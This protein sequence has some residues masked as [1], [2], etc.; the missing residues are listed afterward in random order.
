MPTARVYFHLFCLAQQVFR[1][2][3][4]PN[5]FPDFII[6]LMA[7]RAP[8]VPSWRH[9]RNN[10]PFSLNQCWTCRR[11]IKSL[12]QCWPVLQRRQHSGHEPSARPEAPSEAHQPPI[13]SHCISKSGRSTKLIHSTCFFPATV[14]V[15]CE[16]YIFARNKLPPNSFVFHQRFFRFALQNS[17]ISIQSESPKRSREI[18]Q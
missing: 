10:G 7:H 2:P 9:A 17:L 14:W 15:T 6:S 16:K 12:N 8:E 1:R 18:S 3:S 11:K 4:P 13:F 5:Q